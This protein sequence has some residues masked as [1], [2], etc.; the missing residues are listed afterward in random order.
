MTTTILL[1]SHFHWDREWYRTYDVFRG[2][3]VD[4]IDAVLD[5]LDEDPG[6][7]FVL[8]GQAIVLDDYLEVRPGQRDR[9]AA[10]LSAGRLAAGPWYVQPDS[11]LPSGETH[12]RNLLR[13]R[14]AAGALGPVSGVAYVPD[15]FGH[16]AQFP[17]LFAG[18]GLDPFIYWRGNGNELDTLGPNYRWVAPDGS[19]VRAW[20]L[21]EGYFSAGA[22]DAD[23]DSRM[24]P[25]R[26]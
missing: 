7:C 14:A 4:A 17:Q 9:L 26:A 23:D 8:D 3:L 25:P 15:S 13:G 5:H 16:P 10:G 21:G 20:Q 22:L 19:A 18:F 6:F 24:R 2:R 11:L 1:V 12:V